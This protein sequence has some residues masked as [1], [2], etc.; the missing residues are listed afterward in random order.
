MAEIRLDGGGVSEPSLSE[1]QQIQRD[2]EDQRTKKQRLFEILEKVSPERA[3][4]Y[5]ADLYSDTTEAEEEYEGELE[6]K[7]GPDRA[8]NKNITYFSQC[9]R[10]GLRSCLEKQTEEE[11]LDMDPTPVMERL[12][13][14]D[15]DGEEV[16]RDF[17]CYGEEDFRRLKDTRPAPL[18][19]KEIT[20][21][22]IRV[23][24]MKI[25]ELMNKNAMMVRECKA[26][27]TRQA[28]ERIAYARGQPLC[29][30]TPAKKVGGVY[31]K[32][33]T[34]GKNFE[35]A[36]T[37]DPEESIGN[38]EPT[39]EVKAREMIRRREQVERRE[40]VIRRLNDAKAR[41]EAYKKRGF[42]QGGGG[43][44][45]QRLSKAE[46]ENL[47]LKI[48]QIETKIGELEAENE[49]AG[50]G[51]LDIPEKLA[52]ETL[53][54]IL[55]E[56]CEEVEK[57]SEC[58]DPCANLELESDAWKIEAKNDDK[59]YE[60]TSTSECVPSNPET[61]SINE[62][63]KIAQDKFKRL[64][65]DLYQRMATFLDHAACQE[66]FDKASDYV[67]VL[68]RL[69]VL[70]KSTSSTNED[71]KEELETKRK[72]YLRTLERLREEYVKLAEK[73]SRA[74]IEDKDR[75]SFEKALEE[76]KKQ[77]GEIATDH[78][79][80]KPE[81]KIRSASIEIAKK[82]SG[83]PEEYTITLRHD[84][85]EFDSDRTV[86]AAWRDGREFEFKGDGK[87]SVTTTSSESYLAKLDGQSYTTTATVKAVEGL[88]LIV[89]VLNLT[90]L[91]AETRRR[92]E[93]ASQAL[94]GEEQ[95]IYID[96]FYGKE[97][98]ALRSRALK[99][100][101]LFDDNVVVWYKPKKAGS[102]YETQ[103][104]DMEFGDIE[105]D[106]RVTSIDENDNKIVVKPIGRM[107][108]FG[109]AKTTVD[110]DDARV[111]L[112]DDLDRAEERAVLSKALATYANERNGP[113]LV[114]IVLGRKDETFKDTDL[115]NLVPNHFVLKHM[116]SVE[117]KDRTFG[118]L[119][120]MLDQGD[121]SIDAFNLRAEAARHLLG[122]SAPI[123]NVITETDDKKIETEFREYQT[124]RNDDQR[125]FAEE[126][127][128]KIKLNG[129][130]KAQILPKYIAA[131]AA[132]HKAEEGQTTET[133]I[134]AWLTPPPTASGGGALDTPSETSSVENLSLSDEEDEP[135]LDPP[136]MAGGASKDGFDV[137]KFYQQFYDRRVEGG[138]EGNSDSDVS[139][140]STDL[141]SLM[142]EEM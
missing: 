60:S 31:V 11:C 10:A 125:R 117:E 18:D 35:D 77:A 1:R 19:E 96:S 98:P 126:K 102:T 118:K 8:E 61:Y 38:C 95:E 67:K 114:N 120:G 21:E 90:P 16:V 104:S 66:A 25:E 69:Q 108:R 14:R 20:K 111:L 24:L 141:E 100:V 84:S 39:E 28:C 85:D 93:E 36:V 76:L 75:R 135:K 132:V 107:G 71:D 140:L 133:T 123:V 112:V 70:P 52:E 55:L 91:N 105:I 47:N 9:A 97:Q 3:R 53:K 79:D 63:S 89:D 87:T 109:F 15:S 43:A 59:R 116:R 42:V 115:L 64:R 130:M 74:R 40:K 13:Y 86:L 101:Q 139:S 17:P 80:Y 94:L 32:S 12:R 129:P 103:K 122:P 92:T 23:A 110:L 54:N 106:G 57:R 99:H 7:G 49:V 30:F 82:G 121:E 44:K 81:R 50:K 68:V 5:V 41:L 142:S 51:D 4:R 127:E 131:M 136:P 33:S 37:S 124:S 26:L 78:K 6:W 2:L 48:K 34:P 56:H 83:A 72:E 128:G 113:E 119:K 137:D 73:V 134:Q 62:K 22:Y 88:S 58:T 46:E 45:K 29:S 65:K 27:R 138:G